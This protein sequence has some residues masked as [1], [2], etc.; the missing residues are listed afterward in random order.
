MVLFM[1][2]SSCSDVVEFDIRVESKVQEYNKWIETRGK[3]CTRCVLGP[4]L[5]CNPSLRDDTFWWNQPYI[6]FLESKRGS[7]CRKVDPPTSRISSKGRILLWNEG[8][9]R[10]HEHASLILCCFL[11]SGCWARTG[12]FHY[13]I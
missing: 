5:P 8:Q 1:Y 12:K 10:D 3:P 2:S 6:C 7:T 9:H 13:V 11:P 4:I